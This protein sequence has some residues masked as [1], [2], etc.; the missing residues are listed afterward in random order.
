[1]EA[2]SRLLQERV[3]E[4]VLRLE[5]GESHIGRPGTVLGE[6]FRGSLYGSSSRGFFHVFSIFFYRFL[7]WFLV[8]CVSLSVFCFYFIWLS[9][10]CV[11]FPIYCFLFPFSVFFFLI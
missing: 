7:L 8:F 5:V 9:L 2:I 1:M 3:G 6:R 10:F 11:L 4:K